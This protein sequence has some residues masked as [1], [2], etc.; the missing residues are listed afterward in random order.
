M[1]PSSH[2]FCGKKSFFLRKLQKLSQTDTL[3]MP[4]K[5][6]KMKVINR[7]ILT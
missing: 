6:K 7:K 4:K 1:P 5:T 3:I 2:T